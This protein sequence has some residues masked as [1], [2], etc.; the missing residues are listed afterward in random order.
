MTKLLVTVI[1]YCYASMAC[2][3]AAADDSILSGIEQKINKQLEE[4]VLIESE[5][6][7]LE[8]QIAGLQSKI[9]ER[10][11]VLV[12]RLRALYSMKNFRWGELL[13]NTDVSTLNRNVKILENLNKFDYEPFKEYNGSLRLLAQSRKNLIETESLLQGNIQALKQQEME[14]NKI[15]EIHQAAL[16]KDNVSS[17][18]SLKGKLSRPLEGTVTQEFGSVRDQYRQYFLINRGEFYKAKKSS[19]VKAIGLGVVIFRDLLAGWRETLVV[20]HDDN[21]YSIYA[22]VKNSGKQVGDPVTQ[23]EPLGKTANDEF[24]FELRHYNNP[25]N[26]KTWYRE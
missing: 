23:D 1:F 3:A 2:A 11:L 9:K 13:L 22:G 26:P 4:K 7:Q 12:K 16:Q 18:L 10:K 15:E 24:Y 14:F 19:M 21:Y 5:K 17:L 20:Q 8:L 6:A 25:I